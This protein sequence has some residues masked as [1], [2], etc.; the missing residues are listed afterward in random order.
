MQELDRIKHTVV[1]L[2]ETELAH[3]SI[4]PDF[5]YLSGIITSNRLDAVVA[6][7]CKI[8]RSAAKAS[9]L[10]DGYK[11]EWKKV[12]PDG[13]LVRNYEELS[14]VKT[15]F[16]TGNIVLDHNLYTYND[17]AT[18]FYASMNTSENTVPLELNRGE[19]KHRDNTQSAMVIYGYYPLMTT[20]PCVHAN[21][22]GVCPTD[23]ARRPACHRR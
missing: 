19:I 17:R 9:E 2:S 23:L 5:A 13:V 20:A 15:Y 18:K 10:F 7:I 3:F 11:D 4:Q 1:K 6:C 8:S 21:T 16:G 22:R 14:S 12:Q